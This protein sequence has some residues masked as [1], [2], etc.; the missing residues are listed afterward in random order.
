MSVISS[1]SSGIKK[2]APPVIGAGAV[3]LTAYNA[4]V[5]GKLEA[6]TYSQS[7]EADRMADAA[8]NMSLQDEPNVVTSKMKNKIFGFH[9]DNNFFMPINA[10]IGYIKGV[11]GSLVS[12][13]VPFGLGIGALLAKN[14]YVKNGSLIGLGLYAGYQIFHEGFGWGRPNR[15]NAPFK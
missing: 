1:I 4:H 14:K 10:T 8:W 6:D 15:L 11:I 2:Y 7:C 13:V 3:A 5:L 12:N 9:L